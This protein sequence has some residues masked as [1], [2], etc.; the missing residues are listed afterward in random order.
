MKHTSIHSD[1]CELHFFCSV[2]IMNVTKGCT[3]V[4][5]IVLRGMD[6]TDGA[7]QAVADNCNQLVK[8]DISNPT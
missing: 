4:Q 8:L 3:G 5:E 6:L 1:L 2:G 7:I